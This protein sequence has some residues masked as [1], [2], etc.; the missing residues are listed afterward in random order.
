MKL[1]NALRQLAEGINSDVGELIAYAEGDSH[2]GWGP[3]GEWP[4]GAI[5][6]SE[7]R[8][9]YAVVRAM[10]PSVVVEF[11]VKNGCSSKHILAALVR[12][13]RGR[14]VSYDPTPAVDEGNFTSAQ[15]ERWELVKADARIAKL[16]IGAEIV[17][18]DTIHTVKCTEMLVKRAIIELNPRIVL[19]HDGEHPLVGAYVRE[20]FGNATDG[21]FRTIVTDDSNCGFVYWTH[22]EQ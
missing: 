17:F 10:R 22:P 18:E 8:I 7:G 6:A 16:P 4:I 19:A 13:Q 3:Q 1:E 15:L 14:L 9:L 2:S 12:N 5:F 20:G 11:G 21:V